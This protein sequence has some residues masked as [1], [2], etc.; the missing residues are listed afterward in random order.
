MNVVRGAPVNLHKALMHLLG[1]ALHMFSLT[2][3]CVEQNYAIQSNRESTLFDF[4]AGGVELVC[5]QTWQK[6]K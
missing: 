1:V 6:E 2:I 4:Q 5:E 3:K